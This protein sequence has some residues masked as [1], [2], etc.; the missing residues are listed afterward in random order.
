MKV[1]NMFYCMKQGLVNIGRHKLYSFAS[2]LTISACIFLFGILYATII[3]V[4]YMLH[5]TEDSV[6]ITVF[7]EDNLSESAIF[8]IGD[9]L[10]AMPE[11]REIRYVSAQQAWEQFKNIYFSEEASYLAEGFAEDNPLANSASYFISLNDIAKQQEV[12]NTLKEIAGIRKVNFSELAAGGL[13]S[14]NNAAGYVAGALITVLL[15]ISVF[16]ISNTITLAYSARKKE[17]ILMKWLGATNLFVRSPFIVE[18]LIIGMVGG[19]LPNVIIYFLYINV[20]TFVTERFGQISIVM[21]NNGE[22]NSLLRFV[23]AVQVFQVLLPV[24]LILGAGIGFCGSFFTIRKQL[25]V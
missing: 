23:P 24:A 6:G 12:A 3:N 17:I 4:Q 18:G 2:V 11:I 16:L 9:Q 14:I 5:T 25:K 22:L 19:V 20:I 13:R 15:V 10:E 21:T 7:F 8:A 1:N